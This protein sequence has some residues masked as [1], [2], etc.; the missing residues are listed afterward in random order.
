[1]KLASGQFLKSSYNWVRGPI[2][3]YLRILSYG[4]VAV[5]CLSVGTLAAPLLPHEQDLPDPIRSLAR[6]DHVQIQ[7]IDQAPPQLAKYGI[8]A[9]YIE[10]RI[11]SRFDEERIR[12]D[13]NDDS[14]PLIGLRYLVE[15]EPRV[16][17]GVAY[18]IL[19][20][21]HQ[22]VHLERL[23]IDMKVPTYNGFAVGLEH[24]DDFEASMRRSIE[25]MIDGL[26][27]RIQA[28]TKLNNS[29]N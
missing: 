27:L 29:T 25:A 23:N 24:E 22:Q 1:M 11:R 19:V 13:Q 2:H 20:Q 5:T 26:L 21:L 16:E 4:L 10:D 8:T 3:P 9:Q 7:K 18:A 12:I 28:A 17:E 14:L 15:T 6:I